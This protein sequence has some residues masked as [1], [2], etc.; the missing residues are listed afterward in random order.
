MLGRPMPAF[1]L[2][3]VVA[4]TTLTL[5][6]PDG[7]AAL[8]RLPGLLH[9]GD[10]TAIVTEGYFTSA[11]LDSVLAAADLARDRGEIVTLNTPYG[12]WC[13]VVPQGK[14]P[15]IKEVCSLRLARGLVDSP[16]LVPTYFHEALPAGFRFQK[17]DVMPAGEVLLYF[18]VGPLETVLFLSPVGGARSMTYASSDAT[19]SADG[20]QESTVVPP[21]VDELLIA[22]RHVIWQKHDEDTR[23]ARGGLAVA[24]PDSVIGRFLWEQDGLSCLLDGM[25]LTRHEG[26]K[27]IESLHTYE[28]RR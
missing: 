26:I 4:A 21:E 5:A 17:A 15:C 28:S 7:R 12:G 3:I 2:G 10:H 1:G 25:F 9:I 13:G 18:G 23:R 22:G 27:I 8:A 16:L 6:H 14:E 19:V 24:I 11:Q 20:R